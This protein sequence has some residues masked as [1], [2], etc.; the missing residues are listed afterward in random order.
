MKEVIKNSLN[1]KNLEKILLHSQT[2]V[3]HFYKKLGFEPEGN[4]FF[5]DDIPHIKMIYNFKTL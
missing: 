4:E 5:E 3:K 2:Q 1:K